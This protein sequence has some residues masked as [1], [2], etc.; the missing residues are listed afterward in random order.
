M[1]S[2]S[3]CMMFLNVQIASDNIGWIPRQLFEA[4]IS[5]C[6]MKGGVK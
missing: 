5:E 4:V 6:C 2:C 3:A 1:L